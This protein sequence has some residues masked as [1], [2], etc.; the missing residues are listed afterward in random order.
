MTGWSYTLPAGSLPFHWTRN[1]TR[2][3]PSQVVPLT[4]LN[5]PL[6]EAFT[7]SGPPLSL[8]KKISVSSSI[9]ASRS[10][11]SPRPIAVVQG[12]QHGRVGPPLLVLDVREPRQVLLGRLHRAVDGVE[13]PVQEERLLGLCFS[14]NATPSRAKASVRY[15]FSWT[16]SL[17]RK[18][19]VCPVPDRR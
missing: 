8:M 4:P 6:S 16:S 18:M 19:A 11:A 7:A 15:S 9:P 17:P 1:G 5:G 10:L 2:M 3:P 13:R 14:M 12:R